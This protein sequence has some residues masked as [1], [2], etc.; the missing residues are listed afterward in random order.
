MNIMI[1]RIMSFIS[2]LDRGKRNFLLAGS[3]LMLTALAAI[4]ITT[5]IYN[6]GGR[7]YAEA[8]ERYFISTDSA[9][10]SD[11]VSADSP[12]SETEAEWW[13]LADADIDGISEEYP[14]VVGWICFE[15]GSVNYPIVCSED[16]D[17]YTHKSY[18]GEETRSGS[19]FLDCESSPDFTDPHTLMYGHNMKDGSMFGTLKKYKTSRNY[20]SGHQYFQIFTGNR[21]YRYQIFAFEDVPSTHELYDAYGSS[22]TDFY[23]LIEKIRRGSYLDTGVPVDASDHILTLSTC[24]KDEA[25]RFIIS[26]VRVGEK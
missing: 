24:A 1:K 20:Y 21:K 17:D 5:A 18:T 8:A 25:S 23:E 12:G 9:P 4:L 19:I 22:P 11:P 16:N 13:T 15:D 26:A 7:I 10:Y 3:I 2:G 6:E 14:D